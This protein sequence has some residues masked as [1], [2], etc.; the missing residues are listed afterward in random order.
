MK[1]FREKNTKANRKS[2]AG[3]AGDK[4][5]ARKENWR[6]S[7]VRR[8]RDCRRASARKVSGSLHRELDG[9]GGAGGGKAE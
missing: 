3:C 6:G 4:V 8:G 5:K 7:R 9:A 2:E 1:D